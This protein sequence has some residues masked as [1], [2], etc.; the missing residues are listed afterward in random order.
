M[1]S[2]AEQPT[3]SKVKKLPPRSAVRPSDC[4]NLSS[5]FESDAAWETA[6]K[7]WEARIDGYG[8]TGS[9][10]Q[11]LDDAFKR[12]N[13]FEADIEV[14]Q[15][16]AAQCPAIT[17]LGRLRHERRVEPNMLFLRPGKCVGQ[18]S[19][20]LHRFPANALRTEAAGIGR[21]RRGFRRLG[22]SADVRI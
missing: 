19:A 14:R 22:G 1:K 3:M 8:A 20:N 10:F 6:F 4:W 18:S 12:T 2:R 21:T 13:G 16:T 15:V 7:K 11:M 5:L 17:F 9:P